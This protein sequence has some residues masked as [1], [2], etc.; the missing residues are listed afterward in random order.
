M[1]IYAARYLFSYLRVPLIV[2]CNI[3]HGNT[4]T[5]P[6]VPMCVFSVSRPDILVCTCETV[7]NACFGVPLVKAVA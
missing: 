1:I 6:C 2:N 5:V 4:F 7:L 3:I